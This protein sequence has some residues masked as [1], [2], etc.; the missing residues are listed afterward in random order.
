MSNFTG[1]RA[2]NFIKSAGD[3]AQDLIGVL[4][5]SQ[6]FFKGNKTNAPSWLSSL[7]NI[8][9]NHIYN[10]GAARD[11]IHGVQI[12]YMS[13]VNREYDVTV[14][15]PPVMATAA[16]GSD[17]SI[18]VH[19]GTHGLSVG[20][21]IEITAE[22]A[23]FGSITTTAMGEHTVKAVTNNQTFTIELDTSANTFSFQSRTYSVVLGIN[24]QKAVPEVLNVPYV[25][26]NFFLTTG[27]GT[28]TLDKTSVRNLTPAKT[29]FDINQDGH[30]K[31]GI[32]IAIDE[33]NVNFNAEDRLYEFDMTMLAVDYLL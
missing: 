29:P 10:V 3:K 30:R 33:F 32:Q 17:T 12:P 7:E 24:Y 1:G 2:G 5:N 31:S 13:T 23:L 22:Y 9:N 21:S 20:D 11:Y 6:N 25:Q 16:S 28:N 27:H 19:T 26:R 18:N 8:Y 15:N 4:N 14:D